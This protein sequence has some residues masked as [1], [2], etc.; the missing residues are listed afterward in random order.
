MI[1]LSRSGAPSIGSPPTASKRCLR[2]GIDCVIACWRRVIAAGGVPAGANSPIQESI[3]RPGTPDCLRGL[4]VDYKFELGR[5]LDWQI[6]RLGPL[7]DLVHVGCCAA[8][9]VWIIYSEANQPPGR[10]IISCG[11]N[12]WQ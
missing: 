6:G 8:I 7:N 9:Q 4:L 11:I 1:P 2:S 3:S 12:C 5:L 10:G